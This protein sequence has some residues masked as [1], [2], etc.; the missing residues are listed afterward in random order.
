[1]ARK[2][3]ANLVCLLVFH[4]LKVIKTLW[5]GSTQKLRCERCHKYFAINHDV[6]Y[7]GE[8]DAEDEMFEK[9]GFFHVCES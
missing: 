7:F 9:R 8:W 5:G 1:M 2:I 4:R 3:W 6:K